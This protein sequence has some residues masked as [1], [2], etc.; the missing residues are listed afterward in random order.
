MQ[1]ALVRRLTLGVAEGVVPEASVTTSVPDAFGWCG[2][3]A[4]YI[5]VEGGPG[6]GKSTVLAVLVQALAEGS[7][8]GGVEYVPVPV[9]DAARDGIAARLSARLADVPQTRLPRFFVLDGL[10]ASD[11]VGVTQLATCLRLHLREADRVVLAARG[12]FPPDSL[13]ADLL[14]DG[15]AKIRLAGIPSE[16]AERVLTDVAEGAG[17]P[18]SLQRLRESLHGLTGELCLRNPL[19]LLMASDWF[20]RPGHDAGP[21]PSPLPGTAGVLDG[22]IHHL[23]HRAFDAAAPGQVPISANYLS[24]PL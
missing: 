3:R 15:F 24:V 9:T 18:S 6:S 20:L 23:S 21:W 4:R 13:A 11:A 16:D 7:P 1:V 12:P 22:F 2:K 8:I 19:F 10:D 17:D 5:A 14:A